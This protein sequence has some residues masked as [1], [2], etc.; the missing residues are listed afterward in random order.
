M[1]E[2]QWAAHEDTRQPLQQQANT[3]GSSSLSSR[4]DSHIGRR[5]SSMV[6][7]MHAEPVKPVF[8]CQC[9]AANVP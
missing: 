9:T 6:C 7:F 2:G 5:R 8:G 1:W 3:T 4:E